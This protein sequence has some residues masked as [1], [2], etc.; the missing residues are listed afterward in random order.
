MLA[1]S[2]QT[3][4]NWTKKLSIALALGTYTL[5]DFVLVCIDLNHS[6]FA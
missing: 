5:Y 6:I 3:N 4:T 2:T 1:I